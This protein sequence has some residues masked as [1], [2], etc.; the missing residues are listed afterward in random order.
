MT[1]CCPGVTPP[2]GSR[3]VRSGSRTGLSAGIEVGAAIPVG[4][5]HGK[6]HA[7]AAKIDGRGD[8]GSGC[9]T[10]LIPGAVVGFRIRHRWTTPP[11]ISAACPVAPVVDH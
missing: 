3:V 7:A 6:P 2:R 4:E 5:L 10:W 1:T 11:P 9:N 8:I